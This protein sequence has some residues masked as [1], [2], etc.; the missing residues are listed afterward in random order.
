MLHFVNTVN[1]LRIVGLSW[2]G[3]VKNPRS[4][5]EISHFEAV[6]DLNI[7]MADKVRNAR[8]QAGHNS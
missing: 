3:W 6:Y 2:K 7:H 1:A 5:E 8:H 4:S